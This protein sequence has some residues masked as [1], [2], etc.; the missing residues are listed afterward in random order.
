[1]IAAAAGSGSTDAQIDSCLP[2]F[3]DTT[4]NLSNLLKSNWNQ[5]EWYFS[6]SF[7][8][9]QNLSCRPCV[10]LIPQ[11]FNTLEIKFPCHSLIVSVSFLAT[12]I[13]W[14]VYWCVY[15]GNRKMLFVW[16]QFL[17]ACFMEGLQH[18]HGRGNI[19][20]NPVSKSVIMLRYTERT[21]IL[22][23]EAQT[24]FFSSVSWQ[25]IS[26]ASTMCGEWRHISSN[27]SPGWFLC[28]GAHPYY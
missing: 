9:S 28:Q 6:H 5:A 27:F 16:G 1:M 18:H 20:E 19:H 10:P 15:L 25:K 8:G 2:F 3:P 4:H 14:R 7:L 11:P 12:V 13:P 23:T 22:C 26:P 24:R 17:D 21:P